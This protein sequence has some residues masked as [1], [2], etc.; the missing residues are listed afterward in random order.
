MEYLAAKPYEDGAG[1]PYFGKIKGCI[2]VIVFAAFCKLGEALS[3]LN[4]AV[5]SI[6]YVVLF[7]YFY[8]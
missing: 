2:V 5:C 3:L 8:F 1:T 7:L 6:S 4:A